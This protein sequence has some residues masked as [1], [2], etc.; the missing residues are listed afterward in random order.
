MELRE[1]IP[2]APY[3]TLG[4]GGPARYL[5]AVAS[6]AELTEALAIANEKHLDT[7]ILGGGSNLLI[8]DAGFDGLVIRM[9]I[10]GI[11]RD[12]NTLRVGAGEPWDAFVQQTVDAG[13]AGI[14]CLAGIPGTVGGTPVQ[15]VGAYGEEVSSTI[16]I[17]RAFDTHAN[18]FVDLDNVQCGFAYR[19][20]IFNTVAKGRYIVARVDFQLT[21]NGTPNLKYVD[22]A[23]RFADKPQPS[24]A[25]IATAVR[26][27][28]ATKGM[29]TAAPN[30]NGEYPLDRDPDT[31]S[32]G[33]F[34]RNP[35][36]PAGA[37][38]HI[39]QEAGVAEVPHWPAGDG[40]TK[41]PAA[42]LIERAGFS[43]GFAMGHAAI[44]SR[45]TLALTNKGGA[46]AA[47]I[48]ALRDH[49]AKIVRERFHVQ[50]EQEPVSVP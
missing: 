50:L 22:L 9:A 17:V 2:L 19:T 1:N 28:R 45:H 6:E 34:F 14:E 32:A 5:C 29:V 38:A 48:A 20:S 16:T 26:E 47:E 30:Q 42:W 36:V 44:S 11:A 15:N 3:T 41:L 46:K 35:I 13:L 7:F 25:D 21:P 23:K 12:G 4:I 37:V 39:A 33:S 43:K 27:I 8:S 40:M 10:H 24:L 18:Q 31:C 49:V